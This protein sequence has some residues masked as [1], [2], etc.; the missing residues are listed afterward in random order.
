MKSILSLFSIFLCVFFVKEVN[1]H[2]N[3]GYGSDTLVSVY[4]QKVALN[5]SVGLKPGEKQVEIIKTSIADDF[6]VNDDNGKESQFLP[7]VAMD[8]VENFVV[9]WY[10][11]RNDNF[12][13]YFQRYSNTGTA[14]GV[15]TKVNDDTLGASQEHPVIAMDPTGNFVIAW[16]DNRHEN[17][18]IYFQKYTGIGGVL[19]TNTLVNDDVDST[20]QWNPAISMDPAGNFVISWIDE[21]NGNR[22]VY[23]Q[24][25]TSAGGALDANAKVN[26]DSGANMQTAHDIAMDPTGNYV[27]TWQDFRNST[28]DIYFQLYNSNGSAS[29][30]NTKVNDD[31]GSNFQMYPSISMDPA[32]DFVIVWQDYRNANYDIYFQR[33]TGAGL[34]L[35]SNTK[36]NDDTGTMHQKIPAVSMDGS[37]NF[38]VVWQDNRYGEYNPDIFG[39]RYFANGNPNG[40]NYRIVSEGPN[41]KETSPAVCA[42]NSAIVFAWQDNRRENEWDIYAKIVGWNWNGVATS[43]DEIYIHSKDFSLSQNYPNPFSRSTNISF[44]ISKQEEVNLSV[45]NT[46]GRKIATLVNEKLPA[47][48]YRY[49]FHPQNASPGLYLYKLTKGLGHA[50]VRKM[51]IVK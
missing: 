30:V 8:A 19:G 10:D 50:E 23:F 29:G 46:I 18:D 1:A 35:E 15:N 3:E 31:P 49:E 17:Y 21:R 5:T 22:D 36:V 12:D 47:G 27:I 45:Y 16:S 9:V 7:S 51:I 25:Y 13:I 37:G 14:I 41:E 28:W 32:G 4:T 2:H 39:Q 40:G 24:R 6:L 34:A 33:F 43:A 44:S 20:K 38:V 26:D 48:T 11:Y 42:D